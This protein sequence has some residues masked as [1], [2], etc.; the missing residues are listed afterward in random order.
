M[1]FLLFFV[2]AAV[3][4]QED[5]KRTLTAY[6]ANRFL[7]KIW[8][9][10]CGFQI[11]VEGW[12]K[13]DATKAYIFVGNHCN[14]IDL[15][16]TGYFLQHYYKS[17]AKKEFAYMPILGFLFRVAGVFVDRKNAASRKQS[18]LKMIHLLQKG[19]SFLIFPEGTRNKTK[20]PLLPFHKGAFKI[21]I[22][23]QVPI[24]PFVFLN[25]RALQP[26][27]SFRFYPGT[28]TV[29]VLRTVSTV[30]LTE[31][32]TDALCLK[33]RQLMEAELVGESANTFV[34]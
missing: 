28:V 26:A 2:Y 9:A 17:L 3:Y 20:A 30:G 6:R 15:P 7:V 5:K 11:K 1:L 22:A 23:A 18:T 32:D 25:I 29:R 33:V 8:I 10:I 12:E 31:A 27:A 4:F 13:V 14:N 21:A 34:L 16:A 19:V 24:Q